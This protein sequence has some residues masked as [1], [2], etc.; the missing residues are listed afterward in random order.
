MFDG[1]FANKISTK[2]VNCEMM[3]K[4]IKNNHESTLNRI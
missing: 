1:N 4:I 2:V 3:G